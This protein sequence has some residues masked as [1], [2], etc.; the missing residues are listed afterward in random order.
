MTTSYTS[1]HHTV[2][3]PLGMGA[4][5]VG[6]MLGQNV[7][8]ASVSPQTTQSAITTIRLA[9]G[10][11]AHTQ[12]A[13]VSQL[14]SAPQTAFLYAP[15]ATSAG[16]SLSLELPRV[17][18]PAWQ[19][20]KVELT[21]QV[22]VTLDGMLVSETGVNQS[23]DLRAA[24]AS[25]WAYP[26]GSSSGQAS[27]GSQLVT[28]MG[29]QVSGPVGASVQATS[30]WSPEVAVTLG[31][32]TVPGNE[33]AAAFGGGGTVAIGF[34]ADMNQ[35][36]SAAGY[37]NLTDAGP[38]SP[39]LYVNNPKVD[40]MF[41]AT[42]YQFETRIQAVYTF[43]PEASGWQKAGALTSVCLLSVVGRFLVRRRSP[44]KSVS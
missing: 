30:G 17:D 33:Q 29:T 12:T 42:G 10:S 19:M 2:W 11:M 31:D 18:R 43:L 36:G 4:M 34:V 27:S 20:L 37:H 28:L 5:L 40:S 24:G 9:D 14:Y 13:T 22:R 7:D 35:D 44:V 1:K 8:P 15:T 3:K 23:V 16:V 21:F 6:R 26:I 25:T 39:Y 41:G 38:R 32:L